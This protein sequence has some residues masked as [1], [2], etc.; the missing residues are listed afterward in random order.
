MMAFL[1][2]SKA[3]YLTTT[4][5]L[6][7]GNGSGGITFNLTANSTVFVDTVWCVLTGFPTQTVDVWYSTS[8]INGNPTIATPGWSNLV[9]LSSINVVAG[10]LTPIP[11]S[12]PL[13]ITAGSTYGFYVGNPA[14]GGNGGVTYTTYT[15]GTDSFFNSDL[16]IRSGPSTGYG[17]G[18][19]NPT[20]HPRQF[21]GAISYHFAIGTD[22]G[23]YSVTSPT[24]PM[25]AGSTVTV[26]PEITNRGSTTITTAN[27]GYQLDNNP[28]VL[29]TFSGSLAS[30]TSTVYSFTQ[31]LTLPAGGN[32]TL[33]VFVKNPNGVNPDLAPSNDTMVLNLC[34]PI[35][36]GTY[37]VGPRPTADYQSLQQAFDKLMC[38]GMTGSVTLK[39]DSGVHVGNFV[40]NGP[41]SGLSGNTTL[42][43]TSANNNRNSVVLT[44]SANNGTVLKFNNVMNVNVT[45][46]TINK[47]GSANF[48]PSDRVANVMN[49]SNVA[50]VNDVVTFTGNTGNADLI[51]LDH[52]N[53]C[54]VSNSSL[55]G[56]AT[57]INLIG[58]N[59]SRNISNQIISND[60]TDASTA[61]LTATDQNSLNVD[62]NNFHGF[63]GFSNMLSF[64]GV[65]E[66]N[67]S[68][69]RTSGNVGQNIVSFSDFDG[70]STAANKIYNNVFRGD[71]PTTSFS[72][73]SAIHFIPD[74]SNTLDF[75]QFVNNTVSIT[76]GGSA[77][78]GH[79][80]GIYI[81]DANGNVGLGGLDVLNNIFV[82][83]SAAGS[84]LSAGF[85]VY[86]L[87][88]TAFL[89]TFT[90]NNNDFYFGGGANDVAS[91]V[92]ASGTPF[93]TLASWRTFSS[94]D[95][96]SVAQNPVFSSPALLKPI[97]G[98]VDNLGAV[99]FVTS[100]ITGA[101]RSTST[102]DI[103]AYEF[104]TSTT[105]MAVSAI[106]APSSGCNF[107]ALDTVVVTINHLGTTPVS[108]LQV[109]YKINASAPVTAT[110]AGPIAG[111]STLTYRFPTLGNFS[112]VGNYDL[113]AY[114]ST[115]VDSNALNDTAYA[116][117]LHMP[118]ISNNYVERFDSTFMP[119]THGGTNDTWEVGAPA[120]SII[121]TAPSSPN[122]AT[123]SLAGDYNSNEDSYI[124]SSCYNL[125]SFA[126]PYVRFAL[127][128]RSENTYDGATLEA[129]TD[130]GNT[131]NVVG[132]QGSGTNWY[133]ANFSHSYYTGPCWSNTSNGWVNAQN[134]LN[135]LAGASSVIF[136]M[137]FFSDGS[138]EFD[139][140]G[141]DN[142]QVFDSA[143]NIPP[144]NMAVIGMS[145]PLSG[146]GLSTDTVVITV[147]NYGSQA[148]SN[149]PVRY[150]VNGGAPVTA[151]IAGPIASLG[152]LTYRFPTLVNL[153]TIGTYTIKAWTAMPGD[154]RTSDDSATRIVI[155]RQTISSANIQN[156]DTN[157]G[158]WFVGGDSISWAWG[159]PSSSI[160]NSAVSAPNVWKTSLAG[161]YRD[162][163]NSWVQTG[164]YNISGLTNPKLRFQINYETENNYDGSYLEYSTDGGATWS[165]LGD[166]ASGFYSGSITRS[167]YTGDIWMN[168]SAG[169]ILKDISLAPLNHASSV[170]FR[171]H[172]VADGSVNRDGVAID[173]FEL[174]D[175]TGITR[176]YTDVGIISYTSPI[177]NS[178]AD[179]GIVTVKLRNHGTNVLTG[180]MDIGYSVNGSVVQTQTHILSGN[181]NPGDTITHS[182]SIKFNAN[183][184]GA[185][186]ICTYPVGLAADTIKSND[187]MCMMVYSRVATK[188]VSATTMNIYPNPTDYSTT[189]RMEGL[190]GNDAMVDI[191]DA[192]GRIVY[193][194]R[195]AVANLQTGLVLD[196]N[197][198]N[199]GLYLV[200]VSNGKDQFVSRL[201][202][203][204]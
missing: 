126:D 2:I 178:I 40:L 63:N 103:G 127:N 5:P 54:T 135:G 125:S 167:Y 176:R 90:S 168:S 160:I 96:N 49:S 69:N 98:L 29:A 11:L 57:S 172:M 154:T 124:K 94:K 153:S 143:A 147:A 192:T 110:I 59:T 92:G 10:G 164:C 33:K 203:K 123:T 179:S 75:A 113:W 61:F 152:T 53:T 194:K 155:N 116:K 163:E 100:D 9:S 131:W 196:L 97:S 151:T 41:V 180:A 142:F 58:D 43:V 134:K 23:I 104:T 62:Q 193:R 87:D 170:M 106:L 117:I 73:P 86:A 145:R 183:R 181:F 148:A 200:R 25:T 7:G 156:F 39:L 105:E 150:S 139:G 177:A 184:A 93:S 20:N 114:I 129:S 146:C 121:N 56:G 84:T 190:T 108:N 80:G 128:Y 71:F 132:T 76:W 138:V 204:R 3:Q 85:P 137:H 95:A 140:F 74:S 17:G 89:A 78:F 22:A 68:N 199:D 161:N 18:M 72:Y 169:W 77:F 6:A 175:S 27:V 30:M 8:A 34:F 133:D 19:P 165:L 171:F 197:S 162:Y 119:W 50:F 42:T 122:I 149:I 144:V 52:T 24:M 158:S 47:T 185:N 15:S 83:N 136:R 189:I 36:A 187:T 174:Y 115:P 118:V 1:F 4:P 107:N 173:D 188:N 202:V 191:L 37:T 130:G 141:I 91:V 35:S 67:L 31:Q 157:N 109:A 102:P 195:E 46:I 182:F 32:H 99:T 55:V 48:F 201:S 101:T 186:Q 38:G 166:A 64:S 70:S 159:A 14:S 120:G 45:N 198:L 82:A 112:A 12:T 66:L 60:V 13:L 21:N 81:E 16:T 65:E 26:S 88:D 44:D 28:P 51:T 79:G 111:G